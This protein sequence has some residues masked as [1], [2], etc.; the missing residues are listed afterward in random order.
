VTS[1]YLDTRTR[2]TATIQLAFVDGSIGTVHYV[3][4]GSKRFP[5]ERIEAFGG[6]RVL[7]LDNFRILRGYGWPNFRRERVWRQDK[8]HAAEL[9]AFIDAV[10]S[11]G[12]PPIPVDEMFEVSAATLEAAG[13]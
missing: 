11:G 12:P 8:G 4:T 6:D 10:R 5:K 3:A 13:R 9:A 7:Q 2:D 1:N